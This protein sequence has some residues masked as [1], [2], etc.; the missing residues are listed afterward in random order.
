MSYPVPFFLT[1]PLTT[2]VPQRTCIT[3]NDP[4]VPDDA[5]ILDDWYCANPD[6][7]CL[8]VVFNVRARLQ[9]HWVGWFR[10]NLDPTHQTPLVLDQP[11]RA[12]SYAPALLQAL[13]PLLLKD[14]AWQA[15]LRTHYQQVKAVA[16][17]PT[18]PAYGRVRE[19]AKTGLPPATTSPKPKRKKRRG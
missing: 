1:L 3:Q 6:C 13:T 4:G 16:A 8:D 9:G 18:H 17:D 7:H 2:P 12:V 15:E 19:W 5:Y 11:E 14:P 10:W